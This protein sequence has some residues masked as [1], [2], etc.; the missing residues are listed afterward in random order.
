MSS[1]IFEAV[2]ALSRSK[3]I[4]VDRVIEA[5]E[6]A[7][8]AAAKRNHRS[9]GEIVARFD[10]Q[11]GQMQAFARFHVVEEV[12]EEE[13]EISLDDAQQMKPDVTLG[14]DLF[15]P[16]PTVNLGRIAA[17]QAKQ[18]IYQKVR[19]AERANIFAEYSER[20][21]ELLTGVVK[22]R[23]KQGSSVLVLRRR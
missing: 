23:R 2:E 22:R 13:C 8:A 11:T 17:Q 10:R 3:G 20:V 6:E 18:V 12:E 15:F 21:G 4:N 9:P 14:E 5:L 1:E 7:I 19:E 16:R